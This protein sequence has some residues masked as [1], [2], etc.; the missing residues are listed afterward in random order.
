ALDVMGLDPR[1]LVAGPR[2]VGAAL[3]A[4]VLNGLAIVTGITGAYA[5][6]VLGLGVPR[7]LFLDSVGDGIAIV[8]VVVSEAKTVVFG[9]ALGALCAQA[10]FSCERTTEGVGR[11]ANRAVVASVVV[12]LVLN[13]LLNTAIFGLR[14]SGA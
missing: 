8:D 5:M 7:A 2:I 14:G 1:A 13:Y 12:I 11:A 6:S 4:P 3:A 10:G 9:A